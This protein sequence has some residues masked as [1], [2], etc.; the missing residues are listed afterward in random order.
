MARPNKQEIDDRRKAFETY[1]DMGKLRSYDRLQ[2]ALEPLQGHVPLNRIQKW[3]KLDQWQARMNEYDKL[4]D[5][6]D[7]LAPIDTLAEFDQI[8]MLG[9]A[10]YLALA[11]ALAAHPHAKTPQDFKALVD[12]AEKAIKCMERLREL[13]V[14]KSSP[15]EMKDVVN[16]AARLFDMVEQATRERFAAAGTPVQELKVIEGEAVVIADKP[17]AAAGQKQ[18]AAPT[19]KAMVEPVVSAVVETARSGE[20]VEQPKTMAERLAILKR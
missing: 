2:L 18:L 1:R 20:K 14:G 19:E 17:V 8:D 16:R 5:P 13:G 7:E 10:A 15:A 4:L 6:N 11:R 3:A 9:R 12:S